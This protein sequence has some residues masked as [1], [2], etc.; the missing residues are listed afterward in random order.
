[1]MGIDDHTGFKI[2]LI[3]VSPGYKENVVDKLSNAIRKGTGSHPI[4]IL[5]LFGRY[6]ICAIYK[7][8]DYLSGPSKLGS[9]DGIR[10]GNQIFAFPCHLQDKNTL[11]KIS[12]KDPIWGLLFFRTNQTLT[13][14][15]GY[16]VERVLSDLPK[17]NIKKQVT[18]DVLGTTGWAELVFV[19]RGKRFSSVTSALSEISQSIVQVRTHGKSR[20]EQNLFSAKTFSLIGIDFQYLKSSVRSQLPVLFNET[21]NRS[22]IHPVLNITCTPGDMKTVCEYAF[23]IFGKGFTTYGG[24][25]FLIYPDKCKTWG[26]LIEALLKMRSD[27][28]YNIYSTSLEIFCPAKCSQL[29]D[30][31]SV[32][33]KQTGINVDSSLLSLFGKWG[34]Y[35]ESRLSNLY[36]G[37]SNLIQDPLVGECFEDLRQSAVHHL[38]EALKR[39]SPDRTEQRKM[40]W[41]IMEALSYGAE[42]R[43]NGAFLAIENVENR[44][45][46][47]KGGIQRI[48]KAA[49]LLPYHILS[50]IGLTWEGFVIAGFQNRGYAECG[51]IINLPYEYLFHPE[52]WWGLF[53]EVGHVALWKTE[54]LDLLNHNEVISFLES[55]TIGSKKSELTRTWT[56]WQNVFLEIAADS[57]DL[58]F[59]HEKIDPY[60]NNIWPYITNKSNN[61]EVRHFA[62][63]FCIYQYWRY[64]LSRNESSFPVKMDLDSDLEFFNSY[65][66]KQQFSYVQSEEYDREA[67]LIFK[68]VK[69]VV[70]ICHRTYQ[71]RKDRV[72]RKVI[73]NPDN[74]RKA[75][76][77]VF[78]GKVFTTAPISHPVS[79][80][81][82]LKEESFRRKLPISSRIAAILSLW[83]TAKVTRIVNLSP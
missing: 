81:L 32:P 73:T 57:F 71:E 40:V 52:E 50:K 43:A 6:D 36:F 3:S 48:L 55:R 23:N 24:K 12:S 83:H 9:I 19:V 7:T 38:P 45:S 80:I 26:V 11:S 66:N 8:S 10:G 21:Y 75:I 37:I 17:A 63:Y 41:N 13:E 44:F 28:A 64:L 74:T 25:D 82:T 59:C 58:F 5:K 1:M 61:V 39:L 79:F 56:W 42:E 76:K 67:L 16:L 51:E 46:P 68:G 60:F 15:Y 72:L 53:H 20:P 30:F 65:L 29:Q 62:R 18:I 4:A 31:P 27:L 70:E 77:D 49:Q 35:F 69:H 2:S 54:F 47:T 33:H 78:D 34:P 22:N 14:Q